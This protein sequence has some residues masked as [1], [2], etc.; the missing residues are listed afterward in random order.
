MK[1]TAIIS[2]DQKYRYYLTRVWTGDPIATFIMLNPST[3]DSEIDDPTIKRCIKF[4][5][6]WQHGGIQVVNLFAVRSSSP[7]VMLGSVDPVGERN[8]EFFDLAMD[9]AG[10][11]GKV[12]CAWGNHGSFMDQDLTALGWIDEHLLWQKPLCLGLTNNSQPKHPLSR[13]KG[14]IH[15]NFE[16]II[17]E[18]RKQS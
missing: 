1:K 7:K 10:R 5:Q 15:Y 8:K 4:A 17:Y 6:Q 12:I 2:P 14:Y 3:A 13:G 18:G 9:R 16:P 11:D